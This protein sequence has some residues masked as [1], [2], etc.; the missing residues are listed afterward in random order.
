[1]PGGQ[2]L[3]VSPWKTRRRP[4]QNQWIMIGQ[5]Q[6]DVSSI[7]TRLTTD[8]CLGVAS[9]PSNTCKAIAKWRR[10]TSN[11]AC[12]ASPIHPFGRHIRNRTETISTSCVWKPKFNEDLCF[13]NENE[14]LWYRFG[15]N[16]YVSNF[17]I[18]FRCHR[19]EFEGRP[20]PK[21]TFWVG[22]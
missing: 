4:E 12:S 13:P 8:L 21:H 22:T 7:G 10:L 3:A 15:V 18:A 6:K 11:T 19:Q 1:M 14:S 9:N 5:A 2:L 16:K 20:T 17:V